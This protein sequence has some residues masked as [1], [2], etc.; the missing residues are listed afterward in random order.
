MARSIGTFLIWLVSF[1]L[2]HAQ[3]PDSH[4]VPVTPQS[5]LP[6]EELLSRGIVSVQPGEALHILLPEKVDI[7]EKNFDMDIGDLITLSQIIHDGLRISPD[8]TAAKA[9]GHL[10]FKTTSGRSYVLSARGE[11]FANSSDSNELTKILQLNEFGTAF[12]SS[13]GPL[14]FPLF[15]WQGSG[16][17]RALLAYMPEKNSENQDQEG[18]HTLTFKLAIEGSSEARRTRPADPQQ[19]AAA[20]GRLEATFDLVYGIPPRPTVTPDEPPPGKPTDTS[21]PTPTVTATPS[22]TPTQTATATATGVPT[23]KPTP[24]ARPTAPPRP[25]V[26]PPPRSTKVPTATATSTRTSTPTPTATRTATGTPTPTPSATSTAN[27]NG[28]QCDPNPNAWYTCSSGQ[29]CCKGNHDPNVLGPGTCLSPTDCCK[30]LPEYIPRVNSVLYTIINWAYDVPDEVLNKVCCNTSSSEFV[31]SPAGRD[32]IKLVDK[33]QGAIPDIGENNLNFNSPYFDWP[34]PQSQ[35]MPVDWVGRHTCSAQLQNRTKKWLDGTPRT[36][37]L[38]C[39]RVSCTGDSNRDFG[40]VMSGDLSSG[41]HDLTCDPGLGQTN[42]NL[43]PYCLPCTNCDIA[44]ADGLPPCSSNPGAPIVS[45]ASVGANAPTS[46]GPNTC[47]PSTCPVPTPEPTPTRVILT[48]GEMRQKVSDAMLDVAPCHMVGASPERSFPHSRVS[49]W[50]V[51]RPCERGRCTSFTYMSQRFKNIE[52]QHYKPGEKV[53]YVALLYKGGPNEF[54]EDGQSLDDREVFVGWQSYRVRKQFENFDPSKQL[55]TQ[56]SRFHY[57]HVPT[58]PSFNGEISPYIEYHGADP[59]HVVTEQCYK[60]AAPQDYRIRLSP[61]DEDFG[62]SDYVTYTAGD[63]PTYLG[64]L[65][66]ANVD[67]EDQ[68]RLMTDLEGAL[69]FV[70]NVTPF[71]GTA[72]SGYTCLQQPDLVCLGEL[73]LD[74]TS[75]VLTLVGIGLGGKLTKVGNIVRTAQYATIPPNLA[76]AAYHGSRGDWGRALGRAIQPGVDLGILAYS[77]GAAR[78]RSLGQKSKDLPCS[79][80]EGT[81]VGFEPGPQVCRLQPPAPCSGPGCNAAAGGLSDSELSQELLRLLGQLKKI[82]KRVEISTDLFTSLN[83]EGVR[84]LM[85]ISDLLEREPAALREILGSSP[86]AAQLKVLEKSAARN[87]KVII[88]D[89]GKAFA[90]VGQVVIPDRM[91]KDS[92]FSASEFIDQARRLVLHELT[93]AAIQD[94]GSSLIRRTLYAGK[95]TLETPPSTWAV[96]VSEMEADMYSGQSFRQA[97]LDVTGPGRYGRIVNLDELLGPGWRG[98]SDGEIMSKMRCGDGSLRADYPF[99]FGELLP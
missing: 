46:S 54:D 4:L 99:V 26:T 89:G 44:Y 27:T 94:N 53:Y 60:V 67:F 21:T 80:C 64:Y 71:I 95:E 68:I 42:G 14:L 16:A 50:E 85:V 13:K 58:Y 43:A 19:R 29:V 96:L 45:S 90:D 98:L 51:T 47:T 79:T 56:I 52:H 77:R 18:T 76:F 37:V 78:Y 11:L 82:L 86:T 40:W 55:H 39:C 34:S 72:C 66:T 59:K 22:S 49:D 28:Q 65:R 74:V 73:G 1:T 20:A 63:S 91:L 92:T 10:A 7:R 81:H 38:S 87:I 75:D 31:D 88:S 17:P 30:G 25:T 8:S 3:A 2:T 41:R 70:L 36:P 61:G 62:G 84:R 12:L 48:E 57:P 33:Q 5:S 83:N 9:S 6:F 35:C 15:A 32:F 69:T 23:T 97:L 24:S 93:H